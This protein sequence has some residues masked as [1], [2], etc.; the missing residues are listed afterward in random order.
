MSDFLGSLVRMSQKRTIL[1][2]WSVSLQYVSHFSSKY[3][4]MANRVLTLKISKTLL[5]Y[6]LTF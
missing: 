3:M 4:E 2:R 6:I 1:C 5:G